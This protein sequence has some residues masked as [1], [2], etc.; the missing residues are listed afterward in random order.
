[1]K[2]QKNMFDKIT[3]FFTI[4]TLLCIGIEGCQTAGEGTEDEGERGEKS[5]AWSRET[6]AWE[7]E[8]GAWIWEDK[9]T[10]DARRLEKH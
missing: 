2:T 8:A 7:S 4:L 1:M 10:A 3:N 5:A 6:E 9:E